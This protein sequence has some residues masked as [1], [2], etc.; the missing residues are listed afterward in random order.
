[1]NTRQNVPI[2]DDGQ[3]V[4]RYSA[5]QMA[6][7][8]TNRRDAIA[9]VV[10]MAET[11]TR[12]LAQANNQAHEDAN[13]PAGGEPSTIDLTESPATIRPRTRQPVQRM[14]VDRERTGEP[15]EVEGLGM[16][17]EM[18]AGGLAR[19]RGDGNGGEEFWNVGGGAAFGL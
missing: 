1:M 11:D 13:R 18:G 3:A 5:A 2:G 17:V 12:R 10:L 9:N 16:G 19:N 4:V 14:D 6:G 8:R 15:M 7:M